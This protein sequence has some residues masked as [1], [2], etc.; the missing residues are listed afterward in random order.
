MKGDVNGDDQITAQDASLVL[1]AVAGKITLSANQIEAGNVNGDEGLTAQ[2][3]SL[4][5][6]YVAGKIS[7]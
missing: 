1:Q 5:L 6:Q 4:I 3:A 2:D 7:W